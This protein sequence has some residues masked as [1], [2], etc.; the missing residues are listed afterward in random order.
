MKTRSLN[1]PIVLAVLLWAAMLAV[2]SLACAPA[3]NEGAG[4]PMEMESMDMKG[5]AVD[6]SN[7]K[8]KIGEQTPPFAMVLSDG[9]QVSSADQAA[10]G[11]AAHLFWF[12]TW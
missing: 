5:M 3:A 8:L 10:S 4:M 12:A 1:R 7:L 6:E 11:R 2:F 9:T